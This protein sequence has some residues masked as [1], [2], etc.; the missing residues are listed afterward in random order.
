M[1]Q[2]GANSAISIGVIPE[3]IPTA[4][5]ISLQ[6]EGAHPKVLLGHRG[7]SRREAAV[8]V[9][10]P[11]PLVRPSMLQQRFQQAQLRPLQP[12]VLQHTQQ[13]AN[14]WSGAGNL[15]PWRYNEWAFRV[16]EVIERSRGEGGLF[17]EDTYRVSTP[18]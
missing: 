17:Y 14:L 4:R 8:A 1:E 16:K 5:R 11:H 3:A 9:Q 2:N 10:V 18:V 15:S 6:Q 12:Q 7:K 13:A